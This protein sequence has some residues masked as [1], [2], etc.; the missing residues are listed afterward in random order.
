VA[1]PAEA[2]EGRRITQLV[3]QHDNQGYEC[4]SRDE[5]ADFVLDCFDDVQRFS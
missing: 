1:N 5:P 3:V 4:T 2:S